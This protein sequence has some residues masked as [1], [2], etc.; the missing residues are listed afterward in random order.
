M[1]AGPILERILRAMRI[2]GIEAVLVG[3]AAAALQGAPVTTDDFDFLFRPTAR[4]REKLEV[5]ARELGA[6]VKQ[7]QYP[8][9]SFFRI[10][11][12]NDR[13]QV[14]MMGNID[15]VKSFA[16]LRSRATRASIGS[17]DILVAD[18]ADII[19]SKKAAGRKKDLASLPILEETL[20]EK[21]R[22]EKAK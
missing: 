6:S 8:L 7:P 11:D 10:S 14:D 9:S 18:L 21:K 3:N 2:A 16:S 15:G 13:L 1:D 5:M 22:L 20:D 17:E 4:N 19:K 12:E